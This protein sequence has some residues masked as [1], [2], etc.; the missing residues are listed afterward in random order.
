VSVDLV[1]RERRGTFQATV[2][3]RL[4]VAGCRLY[5]SRTTRRAIRRRFLPAAT[6]P[7]RRLANLLG[8]RRSRSST[9]RGDPSYTNI[10]LRI[11]PRN[12]DVEMIKARLLGQFAT[13]LR[14]G[15]AF[16]RSTAQVLDIEP[17]IRNQTSDPGRACNSTRTISTSAPSI[18]R[19]GPQRLDAERREPQSRAAERLVRARCTPAWWRRSHIARPA[20]IG[21]GV[22]LHSADRFAAHFRLLAIWLNRIEGGAVRDRELRT[23]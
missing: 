11:F 22:D 12:G 6:R 3:V 1:R 10:G 13:S 23:L 14:G 15:R 18:F 7:R 9:R 4:A 2:D 19:R 5:G 16:F 21:A 17:A 8:S 20:G